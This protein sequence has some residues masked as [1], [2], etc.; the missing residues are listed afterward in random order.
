VLVPMFTTEPFAISELVMRSEARLP[1][2]PP[3]LPVEITHVWVVGMAY[4]VA[5]FYWA[6]DSGW[7][8]VRTPRAPLP[9]ADG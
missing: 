2:K 7:S 3:R 8:S 6:P 4:D 5:G 1:L 9:D